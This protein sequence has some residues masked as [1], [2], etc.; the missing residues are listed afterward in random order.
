MPSIAWPWYVVIGGAINIIIS[1]I[2]SVLLDGFQK[3]WHPHSVPGQLKA[4][5]DSGAE[6]KV[7]GWYIVPGKID[8]AA[9]GLPFMFVA[10]IVFLVWFGTLG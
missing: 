2:A 9:W 1:W 3:E 7:G 6:Q 4:F 10:I 5:R 8:R